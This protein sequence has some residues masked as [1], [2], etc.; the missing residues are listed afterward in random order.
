MEIRIYNNNWIAIDTID[1][2]ESIIWTSRYWEA[3][4]FEIYTEITQKNIDVFRE[5]YF[6]SI[7]GSRSIMT[8]LTV[9]IKSNSEF[10]NKL[11]IKGESL[12]SILRKRI[13]WSQTILSGN[14]QTEV[15]RLLDENII[16]SADPNRNID[17][18]IY[19]PS[20]NE[21]ITSLTIDVQFTGDNLYEAIMKL[22]KSKSIGFEIIRDNDLYVFSLYSGQN[23]S[24]DQLQNPFVVF[25]QE[26][27]NIISSDYYQSIVNH[28]TVA[29]VAG[30]GEGSERITEQVVFPGDEVS[31]FERKE[32]Y[33][34][35][36]DIS[37]TIDGGTLT[38]EEYKQ[39]LA[40]RGL[41]DLYEHRKEYLFEGKADTSSVYIFGEDFFLG[42]VVQIKN[43][44]GQSGKTRVTEV[45][46]SESISGINI[47]PSFEYV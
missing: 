39:L 38:L 6:L 3:G 7:P 31:G 41:M 44:Y 47:Y 33:V 27:D 42:D 24:Y 11:L 37:S 29:L 21:A 5:G 23:R 36:R 16:N 45:I 19:R 13:I 14:F 43:E 30:E 1:T 32:L 35:A 26:F 4:D 22:C 28:R 34:D 18:F 10:G 8:I 20:T 40:L 2:A 25:S 15:F 9:Q 46:I 12:E 17:N